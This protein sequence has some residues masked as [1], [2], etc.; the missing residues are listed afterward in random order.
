MKKI[1]ASDNDIS[2]KKRKLVLLTT[3]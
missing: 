1:G 3:T 2:M